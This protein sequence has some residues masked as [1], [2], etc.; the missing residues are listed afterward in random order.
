VHDIEKQLKIYDFGQYAGALY[1]FVWDEFCDW[2]VE[3][4]KFHLGDRDAAER[5]QLVRSILYH[6]L[7]TVL[8]LMHP[9]SPYITEELHAALHRDDGKSRVNAPYAPIIVESWP[10]LYF[11][12]LARD[13]EAEE[14]FAKLM[15]IVRAA[16]NLRKSVG[17]PDSREIGEILFGTTDDG[18]AELIREVELDIARLLRTVRIVRHREKSPPKRAIRTTILDESLKLFL[19]IGESIDL[20]GEIAK[21]EKELASKRKYS[22]SLSKKL[23]DPNFV[24]K[25][26]AKVIEKEREKLVET[27]KLIAELDERLRSLREA[28]QA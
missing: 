13:I 2:Y 9:I 25:A 20:D 21:I 1:G 7:E 5:K 27:E 11:R 14:K 12:D 26:P 17:L 22:E 3:I 28:L 10:G 15:D 16:R 6:S 4:S 18:T 23:N 19:P 8:R 24:E